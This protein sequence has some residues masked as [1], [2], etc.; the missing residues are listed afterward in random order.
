MS[1]PFKQQRVAGEIPGVLGEDVPRP[2]FGRPD[3]SVSP[4][5]L[6]TLGVDGLPLEINVPSSQ[7]GN[8][9]PL[10]TSS[11]HKGLHC[12]LLATESPDQ[13]LGLLPGKPQFTRF[14]GLGSGYVSDWV[15]G[16]G[17]DFHQIVG[18]H[19]ESRTIAHL[20]GTA[21]RQALQKQRDVAL[22]KL[23]G[24]E[25]SALRDEA[26]DL[27]FVLRPSVPLIDKRTEVYL[28]ERGNELGETAGFVGRVQIRESRSLY[29]YELQRF[30][31][32]TPLEGSYH[33]FDGESGAPVGSPTGMRSTPLVR[34]V[35]AGFPDDTSFG[36]KGHSGG[37]DAPADAPASRARI[38]SWGVTLYP[39]RDSNSYATHVA[40]DF[41]TIQGPFPA[42]DLPRSPSV[43]AGG[44]EYPASDKGIRAVPPEMPPLST[45]TGD[46]R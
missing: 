45:T 38:Y 39:G 24:P 5:S 34:E 28:I 20:R 27:S 22:S 36:S 29:N 40:R 2:F 3:D 33:L 19:G 21:D 4:G 17:F 1:E 37:E 42:N 7:S 9:L 13:G 35:E 32:E 25:S 44:G 14:V 26:A 16:D 41:E 31:L 18:K 12:P 8:D 43:T 23:L 30:P 46:A 10:D 6:A 15:V 11:G